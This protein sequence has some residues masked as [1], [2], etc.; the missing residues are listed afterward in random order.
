MPI[1]V[2][3]GGVRSRKVRASPRSSKSTVARAKEQVR[4]SGIRVKRKGID[5]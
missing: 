1:G 4:K 2:R 5:F 3:P